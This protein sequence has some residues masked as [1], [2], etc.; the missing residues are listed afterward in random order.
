MKI[1]DL[2]QA[3]GQFDGDMDAAV[4]V[5]DGVSGLYRDI[6]T[7]RVKTPTM[8]EPFLVI[9]TDFVEAVGKARAQLQP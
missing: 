1:S 4:D 8:G 5:D 7:L 2:L 9:D 3:L 6:V